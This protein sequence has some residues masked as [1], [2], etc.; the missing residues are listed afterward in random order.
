MTN[1]ENDIYLMIPLADNQKNWRLDELGVLKQA[2]LDKQTAYASVPDDFSRSLL[3]NLQS[4]LEYECSNVV[5]DEL[6]MAYLGQYAFL[7]ST[8]DYPKHGDQPE[9]VGTS[10]CQLILTAH[11]PT[12][13]YILTVVLPKDT[14][15]DFSTSQVLD[16]LSHESLW[17]ARPEDAEK[18]LSINAKKYATIPDYVDL[19]DY[20]KYKYGLLKCGS[21]KAFL[22][23]S[24]RPEQEDE[25]RCMMAGETYDSQHQDFHIA[26]DNIS[27]ICQTNHAQYDYYQ[28]YM[29]EMVVACIME[30]FSEN[31][32]ERIDITA[33]YAF[34]VILAMFQNTSI[35]KVNMQISNALA[36]DGDISHQE[37][38]GLY[39][40]FGKTVRFW[41]KNNYKYWGTQQESQCI[42]EAFGNKEL[43]ETYYEHQEFLEHIVE[44]K[45]AQTEERNGAILNIVATILAVIQV[46]DFIVEL[47]ESFYQKAGIDVAYAGSTFSTLIICGTF[48]FVLV[49]IIINR[50]RSKMRKGSM[51]IKE[52]KDYDI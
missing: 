30:N 6:R 47:L 7:H 20:I 37:I 28:V 16:Q 31:M 25:F 8:D 13:M 44:L 43:K 9:V 40:N 5:V 19:Y 27:Q 50:M 26:S 3:N 36:N 33:T 17:I 23:L 46:Q 52:L 34:I 42:V 39:R 18:Y 35:E 14:V 4:Y 51:H 24:D 22:L 48:S 41:E 49:L 38:L 21:G 29:S 32:E 45:G 2:S 11:Q 1:Y 15:K 12:H 10:P